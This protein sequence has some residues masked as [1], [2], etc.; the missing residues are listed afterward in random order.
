MNEELIKA[1]TE[2]KTTNLQNGI[3]NYFFIVMVNKV[4]TKLQI[5]IEYIK[6]TD[7]ICKLQFSKINLG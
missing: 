6:N 2:G 3:L 4:L 5:N 1:V 7:S